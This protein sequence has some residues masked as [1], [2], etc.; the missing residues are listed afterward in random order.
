MVIFCTDLIAYAFVRVSLSDATFMGGQNLN[1]SCKVIYKVCA[2]QF[3]QSTNTRI[4][5]PFV[6]LLNICIV[7]EAERMCIKLVGSVCLAS[8]YF[9]HLFSR[10]IINVL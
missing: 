9:L 4:F 10:L 1:E 8:K 3:I 6:I 7:R 2:S 5:I